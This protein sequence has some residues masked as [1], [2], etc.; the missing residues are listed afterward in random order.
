[1]SGT[2]VGVVVNVVVPVAVVVTDAVVAL[3]TITIAAH[4]QFVIR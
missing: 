2:P 3:V 1:M 4:L